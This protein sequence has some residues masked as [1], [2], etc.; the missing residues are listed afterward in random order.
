MCPRALHMPFLLP[1]TPFPLLTS[2]SF[3]CHS[4]GYL[5]K[6]TFPRLPDWAQFVHCGS[7]LPAVPFCPN[8]GHSNEL[9]ICMYGHLIHGHIS[10]QIPDSTGVRSL[11]RLLA[12]VLPA[13]GI[14]PGP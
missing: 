8:T 6:Q 2:W 13:P 10:Q 1:A 4:H 3:Q 9:H 5:L 7:S 12:S 14:V 11:L